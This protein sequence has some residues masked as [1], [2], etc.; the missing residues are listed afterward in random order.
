MFALFIKKVNSILA[1]YPA[2]QHGENCLFVDNGN[3]AI[4]AT[5]SESIGNQLFGFLIVC[6]FDTSSAQH[7]SIDLTQTIGTEE[8]I[9]YS[10]L[11]TYKTDIFSSPHLD[12]LFHPAPRRY[13]CYTNLKFKICQ[14]IGIM[15]L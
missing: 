10:E 9:S 4:I 2:F 1:N 12:F 8:S 13:L 11:L 7:I 6:N 3:Q 15:P 5:F 14:N